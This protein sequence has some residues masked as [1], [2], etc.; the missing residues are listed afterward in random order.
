[1]SKEY[2][3]AVMHIKVGEKRRSVDILGINE[4]AAKHVGAAMVVLNS[5]FEPEEFK[6]SV[7][8]DYTEDVDNHN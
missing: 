3:G 2:R 1:M 4:D 8:Y 6:G 5:Q 7:T